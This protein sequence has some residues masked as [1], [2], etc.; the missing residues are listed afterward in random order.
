[1]TEVFQSFGNFLTEAYDSITASMPPFLQQFVAFFVLAIVIVIYAFTVWKFYKTISKRDILGLDLNK[2]N[3]SKHPTFTKVIAGIFY[4]IEYILIAPLVIFLWF[5][6]LTFLLILIT[7]GLSTPTL[8]I[9]SGVMIAVIRITAYAHEDLS[10]DIAKIVPLTL[11]ATSL[12]N[13]AFFSVDRILG[14]FAEIPTLFGDI[15]IYF[16]FITFL[17][18]ILRLFDFIF[19]LVGIAQ[20]RKP[21]EEETK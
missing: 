12:L 15:G 1:M 21:N 16:V 2:Y 11:L 10:Q 19:S 17:E 3:R 18:V 7:E 8:I 4:L 9:V 14:T 5:G 13:P 20:I 6:L